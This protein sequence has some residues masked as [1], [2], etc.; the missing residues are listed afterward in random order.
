MKWQ[1]QAP[2]EI[3]ALMWANDREQ[4][5]KQFPCTCRGTVAEPTCLARH[6]NGCQ[7]VPP[8]EERAPL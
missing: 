8:T 2:P 4:L 1:E 3:I 5:A 6:W 7:G